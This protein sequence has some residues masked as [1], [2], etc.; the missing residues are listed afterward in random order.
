MD[1]A[2]GFDSGEGHWDLIPCHFRTE[3]Q[4]LLRGRELLSEV[5]AT[6]FY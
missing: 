2:F 6:L 5:L 3:G 1:Y 4:S